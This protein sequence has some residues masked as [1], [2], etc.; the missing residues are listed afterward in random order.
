MWIIWM[1]NNGA[2]L[3]QLHQ[4]TLGAKGMSHMFCLRYCFFPK[5]PAKG[6]SIS[7]YTPAYFIFP[8]PLPN[9]HHI[10][11]VSSHHHIMSSHQI[12]I[13][14]DY[15]IMSYY[16]IISS[17]YHQDHQIIRIISRQYE[18]DEDKQMKIGGDHQDII[19]TSR[20]YQHIIKKV[21]IG[22]WKDM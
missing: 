1:S 2:L 17:R 16:N 6:F 22:R 8:T 15:Q 19:R 18:E 12:I 10:I 13:S 14:S 4:A 3:R 21:K 9:H 7:S 5:A 11:I 20:Y